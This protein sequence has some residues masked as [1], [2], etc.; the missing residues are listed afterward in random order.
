MC[1]DCDF[2]TRVNHGYKHKPS[3]FL[4]DRVRSD[5]QAKDESV[6]KQMR[7]KNPKRQ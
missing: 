4:E 6:L 1:T 7:L 5:L 3:F 2:Y